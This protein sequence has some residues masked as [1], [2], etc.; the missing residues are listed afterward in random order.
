MTR[1]NENNSRITKIEYQPLPTNRY[2]SNLPRFIR[3][4]NSSETTIVAE[5]E[6]VYGFYPNG[7]AVENI[8]VTQDDLSAAGQSLTTYQHFDLVGNVN[9]TWTGSSQYAAS[10]SYDATKTFPDI[11]TY[12]DGST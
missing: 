5:T 2:L 6:Y 1:I 8:T 11:V 9:E 7:Y 10:I 4:Y 12:A 3:R